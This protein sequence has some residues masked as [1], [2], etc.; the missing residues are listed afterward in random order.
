MGWSISPLVS[1]GPWSL[2][3]MKVECLG[4]IEHPVAIP[5]HVI[6]SYSPQTAATVNTTKYTIEN[7]LTKKEKKENKQAYKQMSCTYLKQNNN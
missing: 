4:F 2:K 5:L 1:F 6:S 3:R 7:D